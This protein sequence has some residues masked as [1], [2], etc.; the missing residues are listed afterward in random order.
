MKSLD[1]VGLDFEY[2]P[3]NDGKHIIQVGIASIVNG[4]LIESFT[5]LVKPKCTKEVFN[6]SPARKITGITYE[7]LEEAPSFCEVLAMIY[8]RLNNKL[9]IA[10]S[11]KSADISALYDELMR[12]DIPRKKT[13]WPSFDFICTKELSEQI[14]GTGRGRNTLKAVCERLCINI[15]QHHNACCDAV[16]AT[17]IYIKLQE[18]LPSKQ[19]TNTRSR[20]DCTYK[21]D[22][23]NYENRLPYDLCQKKQ[24]ISFTKRKYE[25]SNSLKDYMTNVEL[26]GE[27]YKMEGKKIVLTGFDNN[28]KYRLQIAFERVGAKIQAQPNG[29]TDLMIMGENPGPKKQEIAEELGIETIKYET[30][31]IDYFNLVSADFLG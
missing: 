10:H 2:I 23:I 16:C 27:L 28:T 20:F 8:N 14:W 7:E 11:A 9:I 12:N 21:Q 24:D 31:F 19:I 17:K 29:K 22:D 6:A 3:T 13:R 1:F 5:T 4:E 25:P 18:I 15:D 30:E 26:P